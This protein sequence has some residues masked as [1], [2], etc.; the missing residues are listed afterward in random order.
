M[1]EDALSKA[2]ASTSHWNAA[3][4][5]RVGGFVPALGR[6]A[7]DLLDPRPGERILDVGCGDGT[8][9][10]EIIGRGA[11]VVGVDNSPELVAAARAAGVHAELVDAAE[12]DFDQRFDAAFSNAAL[13]WMLAK[14]R[15]AAAIFLALRFA[16]RFAGEMGGEGNLARLRD[17]LDEELII[18]GY[19]P[20]GQSSSWYP[21]PDEFAAIYEA[22]GFEAID[23]RLIDRPTPLAHGV[24]QWVTTFRRGW[25]ESAGVPE[26]ERAGIGAAV[27][28]R[29]GSDIAD[30]VR[31][32]FVMRKPA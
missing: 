26:A 13:H 17:A 29:F 20:P 2:A 32:R 23:A 30:Y 22:A 28:G 21:S 3:D 27:A 31:L 7:L 4:Y 5:A 25:L 14:E 24:A 18:R 12:M 10:L 19:A 6:A 11:E 15:V 8:L 16:G 9:S 1:G